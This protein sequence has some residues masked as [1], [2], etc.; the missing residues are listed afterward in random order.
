MQFW[1][2]THQWHQNMGHEQS[3]RP[4]SAAT[5]AAAANNSSSSS[6]NR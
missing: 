4:K 3:F 5:A 6:N 1:V 2:D